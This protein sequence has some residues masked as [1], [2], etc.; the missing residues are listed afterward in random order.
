MQQGMSFNHEDIITALKSLAGTDRVVIYDVP[1]DGAP[2]RS[3]W[4]TPFVRGSKAWWSFVERRRA[5]DDGAD[6]NLLVSMRGLRLDERMLAVNWGTAFANS[7]LVIEP[8]DPWLDLTTPEGLG[9]LTRETV[10]TTPEGLVRAAY[11][12]WIYWVRDQQ[13][14]LESR[15]AT[16]GLGGE[17]ATLWQVLWERLPQTF[18]ADAF[19]SS[20]T[21]LNL[22]E[23]EL[24]TGGR[25]VARAVMPFLT[26][27][28]LPV[29]YDARHVLYGVR[30]LVNAGLAWVQ[31]PEDNGRVYSGPSQPIP[32]ELPD[33][34]L[35]LMLR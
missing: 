6:L 26:R 3:D 34:R 22:R 32:A 21:L 20:L 2:A 9:Q 18:P 17:N 29:L 15:A 11:A 1:E 8:S 7:F 5:L 24:F 25:E 13:G 31:D 10:A 23:A 4:A 28:G 33:E 14:E 35:A 30:Q 16:L 19:L 27:L 12:D